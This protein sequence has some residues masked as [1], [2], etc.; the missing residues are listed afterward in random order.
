MSNYHHHGLA[1][2]SDVCGYPRNGWPSSVSPIS[3]NG[4]HSR[5]T[6]GVLGRP[7]DDIESLDSCHGYLGEAALEHQESHPLHAPEDVV[8]HCCNKPLSHSTM[9][10]PVYFRVLL[11]PRVRRIRFLHSCP[12]VTSSIRN[13]YGARPCSRSLG[14]GEMSPPCPLKTMLVR[15]LRS[16]SAPIP[17]HTR[18][19]T[20]AGILV[21]A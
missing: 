4:R 15:D 12:L 14:V 7:R 10:Y 21:E 17:V 13:E 8:R 16:L 2:G 11:K 18:D 20:A 19:F 3:W 1:R 6:T 9:N 5:R